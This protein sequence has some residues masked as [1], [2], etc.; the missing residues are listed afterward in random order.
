MVAERA[1]RRACAPTLSSCA[2]RASNSPSASTKTAITVTSATEWT[3]VRTT[4][5]RTS[6]SS[7]RV[8]PT[9]MAGAMIANT[10]VPIEG[11]APLSKPSA[12]KAEKK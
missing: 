10:P 2:P 1:A 11:R 4:R 7:G 6:T 12:E 8:A 3:T 5:A 9:Y